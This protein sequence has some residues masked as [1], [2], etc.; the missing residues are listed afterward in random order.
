MRLDDCLGDASEIEL[1]CG[2]DRDIGLG[3]DCDGLSCCRYEDVVKKRFRR[4]SRVVL[5]TLREDC[6]AIPICLC[7]R[8]VGQFGTRFEAKRSKWVEILL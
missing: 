4:H 7:P 2:D 1:Y 5:I 3:G 8:F 6:L